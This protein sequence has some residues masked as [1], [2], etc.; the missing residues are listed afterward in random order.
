MTSVTSLMKR[1]LGLAT[2]ITSL[3]SLACS[4]GVPGGVGGAGGTGGGPSGSCST[5]NRP[6]GSYTNG[7]ATNPAFLGYNMTY[8]NDGQQFGGI[9]IITGFIVGVSSMA[10]W[11]PYLASRGIATFLIDPPTNLDNPAARSRAQLAAL[12]SLKAE[13]TRPGSPLNGKLDVNRLAIAGWSM[14][15]TVVIRSSGPRQ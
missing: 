10:S 9:V 3:T 14:G 7:W 15:G 8:P 4:G 6:T 13:A 12:N 11:G 5:P 1:T 2:V